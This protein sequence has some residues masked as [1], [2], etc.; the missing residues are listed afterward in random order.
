M[1]SEKSLF[2]LL[3]ASNRQNDRVWASD[4]ADVPAVETVKH[5]QK[6]QVCGIMRRCTLSELHVVPSE[7]TVNGECYRENI[8]SKEGL[9]LLLLLSLHPARS[10]V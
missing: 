6:V 8:L 3:H 9:L 5:P 1:W 2:E 10:R 7:T 4:G